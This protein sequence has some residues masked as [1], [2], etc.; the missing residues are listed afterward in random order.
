MKHHTIII[1]SDGETYSIVDGCSLAIITDEEMSE[2]EYGRKEVKDL[3]PIM[4][5]ALRDVTLPL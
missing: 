4:E 2:L 5:I 3:R 1:L